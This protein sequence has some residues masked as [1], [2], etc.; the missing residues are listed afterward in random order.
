MTDI[1]KS[2]YRIAKEAI[3]YAFA[4][5][6]PHS[7]LGEKK[8]IDV[9]VLLKSATKFYNF[10]TDESY[11]VTEPVPLKSVEGRRLELDKL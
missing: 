9:D 11:G 2:R 6:N 3:Q 7:L 1:N 10:M 4:A 5:H 8:E